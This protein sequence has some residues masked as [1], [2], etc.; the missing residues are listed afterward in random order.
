MLCGR[1]RET[2]TKEN[3]RGESCAFPLP[4]CL[5]DLFAPATFIRLRGPIRHV[6]GR[7]TGISSASA[8]AGC[9]GNSAPPCGTGTSTS[10]SNSDPVHRVVPAATLDSQASSASAS[11]RQSRHGFASHSRAH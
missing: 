3:M 11:T 5:P 4:T 7:R 8:G 1:W 10:A 9:H 6:Q 2:F